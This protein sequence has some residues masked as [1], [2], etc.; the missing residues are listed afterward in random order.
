[1]EATQIK[2][3]LRKHKMNFNYNSHETIFFILTVD[4]VGCLRSKKIKTRE[5]TRITI[6]AHLKFIRLLPGLWTLVSCIIIQQFFTLCSYLL[7]IWSGVKIHGNESAYLFFL[8]MK[9]LNN[10]WKYIHHFC[11]RI[12]HQLFF[13]RDLTLIPNPLWIAYYSSHSLV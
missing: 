6:A 4:S 1:M 5:E 8:R 7:V 11:T 9:W 2:Y 13:E 3:K 12:S 10:R